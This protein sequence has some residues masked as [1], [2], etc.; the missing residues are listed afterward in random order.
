[1][2]YLDVLDLIAELVKG[3]LLD[4]AELVGLSVLGLERE[5]EGGWINGICVEVVIVRETGCSVNV[6]RI[7]LAG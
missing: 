2:A 6:K 3:V 1:M 7:S 4:A 5:R